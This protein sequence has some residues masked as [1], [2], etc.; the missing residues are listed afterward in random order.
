[1][2]L[3]QFANG[4]SEFFACRFEFIDIRRDGIFPMGVD[5]FHRQNGQ[6]Q[7]DVGE[8]PQYYSAINNRHRLPV[9]VNAVRLRTDTVC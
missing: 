3:G 2:P 4:Q 8:Y 9:R 6:I 1:L 7:S 5:L